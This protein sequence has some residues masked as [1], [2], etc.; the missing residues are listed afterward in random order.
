MKLVI[1]TQVYENYGA[2]A[3][4]GRGECP[5]YWKAKGG[6]D[7]VVKNFRGKDVTQAVM[8]LRSQIEEDSP[9]FREHI[10]DFNI[11]ADDYLTQFERD[12]LEFDGQIEFPAKE[13][14]FA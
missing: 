5:E 2:H 7:Y 6:N 11:V 9:Y 1:T 13:L 10:V 14:V 4:D 12:Q 8:A 3:W